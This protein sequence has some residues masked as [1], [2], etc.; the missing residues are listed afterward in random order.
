MNIGITP[1]PAP[2]AGA[3]R[4][5]GRRGGAWGG[6]GW[7]DINICLATNMNIDTH[8]NIFFKYRELYS[9]VCPIDVLLKACKYNLEAPKALPMHSRTQKDS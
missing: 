2:H 7:G 3:V 4:R 6:G 5:R 8:I 1:P 9:L